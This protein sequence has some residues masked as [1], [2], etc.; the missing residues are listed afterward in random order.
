MNWKKDV[1][2]VGIKIV[3]PNGEERIIDVDNEKVSQDAEFKAAIPNPEI[4]I[5]IF[6]SLRTITSEAFREPMYDLMLS[7]NIQHCSAGWLWRWNDYFLNI[8]IL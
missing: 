8:Q 4:D 2:T 3:K 6:S 5:V 7:T 1:T